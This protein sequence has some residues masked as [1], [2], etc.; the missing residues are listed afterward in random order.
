MTSA[1]AKTA[2]FTITGAAFT[3]LVRSRMLDDA[4]GSAFR[5]ASSLVGDD[6]STQAIVPAM[7][8]RL[9]NGTAK[10]RGNESDMQLVDD[11]TISAQRFRKR[12]EW[13]FAG[14]IR[15]REKWYQPTAFVTD[16]GPHDI[17]SSPR[18][19]H[20]CGSDEMVLGN[21]NYPDPKFPSIKREVIFAQCGERPHWH[22]VPRGHQE[23][24]DE[25]LAAGRGLEERS[26]SKQYRNEDV[27]RQYRRPEELPVRGTVDLD[28]EQE[29]RYA[30]ENASRLRR[31]ADLR[32]LILAQAGDDLIEFSWLDKM[33]EYNDPPVLKIVGGTTKIPRAPFMIWA[34]ARL[35]FLKVQLPEWKTISPS[36]MKM[37]MDDANHTD[38]IIGGGFDPQDKEF[39]GSGVYAKAAEDLRTRLQDEHDDRRRAEEVKVTTLVTGATV[40]GIAFHGRLNKTS[41]VGSIVVLPNLNPKYLAAVADAAAVITEEGGEVAHLAQIGRERGLPIVRRSDAREMYRPGDTVEVDAEARTAKVIKHYVSDPSGVEDDDV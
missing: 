36:G 35:E 27:P 3:K 4:P 5:L 37:Q 29:A 1:V 22:D 2:H 24:L 8:M 20:Y 13:L 6:P 21:A 32:V 9:C 39:W 40:I 25:Y 11:D 30:E 16:V 10:M 28:A 17:G 31:V 33:S 38:W 15:I 23:A 19:K 34:F 12:I 7:A 26:H 41:P 18:A 14:R